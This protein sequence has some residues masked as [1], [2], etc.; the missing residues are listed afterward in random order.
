MQSLRP[1]LNV[2]VR[3]LAASGPLAGSQDL[4]W[5]LP[6]SAGLQHLVHAVQQRQRVQR[7][8]KQVL[9]VLLLFFC[10]AAAAAAAALVVAG[11]IA[12]ATRRG[13]LLLVEVLTARAAAVSSLFHVNVLFIGPAV[14]ALG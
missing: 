11:G 4:V 5:L 2:G 13:A 7:L 6:R 9:L 10:G 3:L 14:K 12:S 1:H 8:V